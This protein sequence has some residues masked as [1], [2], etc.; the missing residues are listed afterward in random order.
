VGRTNGSS[1]FV[2]FRFPGLIPGELHALGI[3]SMAVA[4]TYKL[5]KAKLTPFD[6]ISRR[7]RG[8]LDAAVK[9]AKES[10]LL[11]LQHDSDVPL[12][13]HQISWRRM[14]CACES[15]EPFIETTRG[16]ILVRI[17]H[18]LI[19]CVHKMG[20]IQLSSP[21]A[22]AELDQ[23][24]RCR[25]TVSGRWTRTPICSRPRSCYD[26][27]NASEKNCKRFSGHGVEGRK[28]L[29]AE[30]VKGRCEVSTS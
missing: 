26:K 10:M 21:K 4:L 17:P 18:A 20:T 16:R 24:V 19:E 29:L 22:G 3:L 7:V 1:H 28:I 8:Y 6:P 11:R 25:T 9:G 5:Q 2:L 27:A 23:Q 13:Y 14:V 30:W 15:R 12:P